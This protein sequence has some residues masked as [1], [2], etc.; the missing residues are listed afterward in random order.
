MCKV[1]KEVKRV[2]DSLN[3]VSND[4]KIFSPWS[5][6][7]VSQLITQESFDDFDEWSEWYYR[8]GEERK[9]KISQLDSHYR[10]KLLQYDLPKSEIQALPQEIRELNYNYGRT[11]EELIQIAMCLYA[12]GL[13][14]KC[15]SSGD[16]PYAMN[17]PVIRIL[18][19]TWTGIME[20]ERNTVATLKRAY[21]HIDFVELKGEKDMRYGVD[22]EVF[23]DGQLICGLQIK[24]ESYRSNSY[25]VRRAK[26]T[27]EL[28]YADY[29][30]EFG[31]PVIVAMSSRGGSIRNFEFY[32]QFNKL[33][34]DVE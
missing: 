12:V 20:R 19:D 2:L 28:K 18:Q 23:H 14:R 3:V 9:K 22:Y 8:S 21:K 34:S 33:L 1:N 27:D 15:I 13:E 26:R 32:S 31:V 6:G 16:L 29:K 4:M 17:V 25:A 5:V 30:R 10:V 11:R 24:P 7:Y